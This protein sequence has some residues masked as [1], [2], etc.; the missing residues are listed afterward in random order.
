M[1]STFLRKDTCLIFH[2][3]Y[4]PQGK[5]GRWTSFVNFEFVVDGEGLVKKRRCERWLNLNV[6]SGLGIIKSNGHSRV[7]CFIG[8]VSCSR[9][10]LRGING[11]GWKSFV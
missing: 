11:C 1:T 9:P 3:V 4:I 8:Y 7:D 2:T 10:G 5:I 6:G